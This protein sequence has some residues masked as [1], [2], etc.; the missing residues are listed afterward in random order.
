MAEM[1]KKETEI[2][3]ILEIVLSSPSPDKAEIAALSFAL[4]MVVNPFV[5]MPP[6]RTA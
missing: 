1:S 6:E 5:K 2:R 4:G 3:R